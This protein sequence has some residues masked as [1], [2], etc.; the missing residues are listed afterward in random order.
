MHETG[1][2][3]EIAY[4][5][6]SSLISISEMFFFYS[7][8]GNANNHDYGCATPRSFNIEFPYLKGRENQI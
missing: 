2:R 1:E 8:W 7:S 6:S 4:R 5:N 3:M